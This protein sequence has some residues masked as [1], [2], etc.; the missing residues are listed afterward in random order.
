MYLL[1]TLAC[2]DKDTG[3]ADSAAVTHDSSVD[4]GVDSA[5]DT[6]EP[7]EVTCQVSAVSPPTIPIET[8]GT[9][10]TIELNC[11]GEAT[12]TGV[13]IAGKRSEWA[14][15][16]SST[17][18]TVTADASG[19]DAT[20]AVPVE[21]ELDADTLTTQ[22][23]AH[24]DPVWELPD[25]MV[26][27]DW[28]EPLT[29]VWIGETVLAYD[30]DQLVEFDLD[31]AVLGKVDHNGACHYGKCFC[32][33]SY[34]R[35]LITGDGDTVTWISMDEGAQSK[36]FKAEQVVEVVWGEK[37]PRALIRV[38]TDSRTGEGVYAAVDLASGESTTMGDLPGELAMTADGIHQLEVDDEG[39]FTL[40]Q[41]RFGDTKPHTTWVH[42]NVW[43]TKFEGP[44]LSVVNTDGDGDGTLD[45]VLV[46]THEG[47]VELGFKSGTADGEWAAVAKSAPWQT[48]D[49]E[50]PL[51]A[52]C[53]ELVENTLVVQGPA[54]VFTGELLVEGGAA[55]LG[56][57][58]HRGELPDGHVPTC[59]AG[60]PVRAIE[61]T[62]LLGGAETGRELAVSES[63]ASLVRADGGFELD[64][65]AIDGLDHATSHLVVEGGS[66]VFSGS[67]DLLIDEREMTCGS[68]WFMAEPAGGPLDGAVW[69]AARGEDGDGLGLVDL[70]DPGETELTPLAGWFDVELA[71]DTVIGAATPGDAD[72]GD[73]LFEGDLVAPSL[74]VT[75]TSDTDGDCPYETFV[76]P[77][78]ST[79]ASDNWDQR[80][81]LGTGSDE[82]CTGLPVPL[83]S[84]DLFGAADGVVMSD[85]TVVTATVTALLLP[86]LSS[87]KERGNQTRCRAGDLNEDGLG[88]LIFEDAL[89]ERSLWLNDGQGGD[90]GGDHDVPEWTSY[91]ALA[92]RGTQLSRPTIV[93][94]IM[95]APM[96]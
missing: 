4:S 36:T 87:V 21:I 32:V 38:A 43:P 9:E 25:G 11:T 6:G 74:V 37:A 44:G 57:P 29:R 73:V 28:D 22:V 33:A 17:S 13:S 40:T 31:G 70:G 54:G 41:Y 90:L 96:N 58:V 35:G 52:C 16:T 61:G 14:Q 89:G 42:K 77:G 39:G 94:V 64:G 34:D 56:E 66:I 60:D 20:G 2:G 53:G 30:D 27:L 81:S 63:G 10:L 91:A 48:N 93:P 72:D 79:D 83:V 95:T 92:G 5:P 62:W 88:D 75:V 80:I 19:L 26:E 68:D 67:S 84:A 59:G 18:L 47:G 3:P 45:E 85:G 82:D 8:P 23:R 76:L 71:P 86:A 12:V 1:L 55:S 50:C 15:V 49:F 7:A 46:L 51:P 69:F 78:V 24:T 65:V